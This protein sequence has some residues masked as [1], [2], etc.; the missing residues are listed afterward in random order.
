MKVESLK[1]VKHKPNYC[2]FEKSIFESDIPSSN[3]FRCPFQFN[4]IADP[5]RREEKGRVSQT[6]RKPTE[7]GPSIT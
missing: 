5:L 7:T 3:R 1:L 6:V 4:S 2:I